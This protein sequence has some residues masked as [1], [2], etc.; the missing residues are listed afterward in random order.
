M[1]ELVVEVCGRTDVGL[2]RDANEDHLCVGDLDR[3]ERVDA[4]EPVRCEIDRRGLLLIVCDGMGGVRGGDVAST[5]AADIVWRE[6]ERGAA[7]DE[8]AVYARLLRR[9]IRIA[10]QGVRE[11][12]EADPSLRGMGTTLSAAGVVGD[13]L[14][15]GQVGDSR[16]YIQR[17]QS[18]VQV[19]RDQSLVSA[20]LSAGQMTEAEARQSEK[21][22]MILQALGTSDDVVVAMSIVELRQG[23]RVLLCSDGLHGAVDDDSMR[24]AMAAS[25]DIGDAVASL[26]D[27]AKLAGGPDNITA[28][29]AAFSGDVLRAPMSDSDAPLFTEFDPMEEGDRALLHT[30]RVARRLARRAGLRADTL[31][32]GIPATGQHPIVTDPDVTPIPIASDRR[33]P[34]HAALARGQ[35]LG[36]TVWLLAVLALI[37]FGVWLVWGAL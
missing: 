16:A 1:P 19:T 33:G 23:D 2:I 8:T 28:L 35:R 22:S 6:M 3:G 37:A 14:V 15:L 10:N 21:R 30:S 25:D 4:A 32:P 18:L 13:I 36:A 17:G 34:A 12:G 31:P 7:T 9:A 20:L 27:R 5:L 26:I 11:A 24:E 29:V